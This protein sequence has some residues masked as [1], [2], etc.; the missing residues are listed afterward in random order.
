MYSKEKGILQL[1]VSF[2]NFL[3]KILRCKWNFGEK[4]IYIFLRIY[5]Q[6]DKFKYVIKKGTQGKNKVKRDL[7]S[8]IISSF[9]GYDIL[10]AVMKCE[11]KELYTPSDVVY[12]PVTD[13]VK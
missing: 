4:K 5:E 7:S 9:N 3:R 2:C 12:V 10:K 13:Q 11:Q 1:D 6:C 8:C